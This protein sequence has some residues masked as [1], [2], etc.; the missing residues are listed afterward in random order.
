MQ[1]RAAKTAAGFHP[2]P[3]RALTALTGDE[4]KS[5]L[6]GMVVSDVNRVETNSWTVSAMLNPKG[7][8]LSDLALYHLPDAIWIETEQD[9]RES[10]ETTL[11]R[12]ALRA[13]IEFEDLSG[14]WTLLDVTGPEA[15]AF[16]DSA[17]E[18]GRVMHLP[19]KNTNTILARTDLLMQPTLRWLVPSGLAQAAADHLAATGAAELCP[20]AATALRMESGIPVFGVDVGTDNLVLEVPAYRQGISFE[21]GCYIGQETVARMHARG[22]KTARHLRGVLTGRETQPGA[23]VRTGER[24]VGVVTS[25]TYSPLAGQ[26]LSMAMIHRSAAEP[27]KAVQVEVDGIVLDGTVVL[28]PLQE[29]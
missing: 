13:A 1:Y 4:R 23:T 20:E 17:P 28:L 24:D 16:T 3:G 14:S 7:R 27:G 19:F 6:H 22:E 8:M 12:Y 15:G 11:R 2:V 18:P 9:L 26:F 21:K 5:F 25:T 10:V 29:G